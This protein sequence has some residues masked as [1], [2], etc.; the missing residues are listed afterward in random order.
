MY[1]LKYRAA[2]ALLEEG[3]NA[4]A[5][6][7][8]ST[9]AGLAAVACAAFCALLSALSDELFPELSE[10]MRFAM[11]LTSPAEQSLEEAAPGDGAG[12]RSAG[13]RARSGRLMML[14]VAERT[15]AL[16]QEL[17]AFWRPAPASRLG[18]GRWLSRVLLSLV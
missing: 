17:R 14:Y 11:I 7:G 16:E 12:S 10:V 18:R 6:R 9:A 1:P 8:V 13:H 5:M 2:R 4:P 3:A 15:D